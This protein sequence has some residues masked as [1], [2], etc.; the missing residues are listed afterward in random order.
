MILD[1]YLLVP[2]ETKENYLLSCTICFLGKKKA[3]LRF[4]QLQAIKIEQNATK[5]NSDIRMQQ[6]F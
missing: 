5:I 2:S 4:T 1:S 3:V 6:H